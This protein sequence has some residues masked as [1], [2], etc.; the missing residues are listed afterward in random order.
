M[1]ADQCLEAR[2]LL[3][4]TQRRLTKALG[5][6]QAHISLFETTGAGVPVNDLLSPIH[7]GLHV[8]FNTRTQ[9][10]SRLVFVLFAIYK[11][12]RAAPGIINRLNGYTPFF[13]IRV[14][15]G[16][17]VGRPNDTSHCDIPSHLPAFA[18]LGSYLRLPLAIAKE[19]RRPIFRRL[20]TYKRA[21]SAKTRIESAIHSRCRQP[22]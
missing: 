7:C 18:D 15:T 21:V 3:G 8:R 5:L 19:S 6:S 16:A 2:R 14:K 1:T 4:L 20:P 9:Q 12:S 22:W 13:H 17:A 11:I 10:R